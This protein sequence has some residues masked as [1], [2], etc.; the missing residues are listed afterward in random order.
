MN[1]T[2]FLYSITN[3]LNGMMYIGV[4]KNPK[5]RFRG[6]SI[7]NTK[8]R[9]IIKSAIKKYGVENFKMDILCQGNQDYCYEMETRAIES[10]NTRKPNGYNICSGGRGSKGLVGEDN[11][12][13]GKLGNLHPNYGK[14]GYRTGMPHTKESKAKMSASRTGKKKS[15]ETIEKM[16][17]TALN[18]SPELKEK[19]KLAMKAGR[20]KKKDLP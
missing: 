13:Y 2:A 5:V 3:A 10:F 14:P 4:T 19:I 11:G 17:Q 12:M 9:S 16:R 15:L 7:H 18:R 8:T 6:H 20:E 1:Q